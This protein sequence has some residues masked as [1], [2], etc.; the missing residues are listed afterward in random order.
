MIFF[1]YF[2]HFKNIHYHYIVI[3]LVEILQLDDYIKEKNYSL[4]VENCYTSIK[5]CLTNPTK[6]S[7]TTI[8]QKNKFSTYK[9]T[10]KYIIYL[11]MNIYIEKAKYV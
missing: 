4:E 2:Y 6:T 1:K 7:K 11:P 9:A 3:S 10:F 8:L 5:C